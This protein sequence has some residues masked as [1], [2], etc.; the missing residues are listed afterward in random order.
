M[1]PVVLRFMG[2]WRE[3]EAESNSLPA[4]PSSR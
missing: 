1:V 2:E 3:R 4:P